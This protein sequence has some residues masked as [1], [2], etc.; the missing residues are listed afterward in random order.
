[1]AIASTAPMVLISAFF[2]RSF[3]EGLVRSGL[4]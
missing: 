1:M 4:K 2:Q 3:V